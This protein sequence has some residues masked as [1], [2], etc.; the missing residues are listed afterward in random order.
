MN[1]DNN[2]ENNMKIKECQ[3][4]VSMIKLWSIYI[5]YIRE[6][7][8]SS[9]TK[10][11]NLQ[12]VTER[13]EQ[14]Q[15]DMGNLFGSVY[16]S[17]NGNRFSELLQDYLELAV[18]FIDSTIK[19]DIE[20]SM[21]HKMRWYMSVIPIVDFLSA[22]DDNFD[23]PYLRGL[24]FENLHLTEEYLMTIIH[25]DYSDDIKIFDNWYNQILS[26]TDVLSETMI[27]R[28]KR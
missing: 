8:V 25:K 20:D 17:Y 2:L 3:L 24:F 26:I 9:T 21:S 27:Y 22:I 7:I 19:G 18:E 15:A 13:L 1:S 28:I 14:N 10:I 5:F 16:G 4:N 23:R 6:Y 12:L 11:D